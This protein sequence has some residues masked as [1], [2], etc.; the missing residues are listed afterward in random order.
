VKKALRPIALLSL[1]ALYLIPVYVLAVLAFKPSAERTSILVPPSLPTLDNF[2][3]AWN[4]AHLAAAFFNNVLITLAATALVVVL[5]SLA[6]YPLC[7]RQTRLNRAIGN[8]IVSC[9][10]VPPLTILV[11]L[12]KFM[13]DIHGINARW[14]MVLVLAAFQLPLCVFLYRNF[15]RSVPEELDEAAI[16]DG[17]NAFTVFTRIL[18]PVLKPVTASV[19]ILCGI[20]V[21][22]DYQFSVFFLQRTEVRTIAIS[23]SQF[24]SQYQNDLSL[25]SAGCILGIVPAAVAYIFLQKYFMKGLADGAVKG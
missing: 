13:A 15:L 11:P 8:L 7:R 1:G 5:G 3:R 4:K 12:Y 18:F 2:A 9:L 17:C 23:L 19:V 20:Q 25:V 10:V 6:A 14:S 16:L 22:N 21:W 24:V